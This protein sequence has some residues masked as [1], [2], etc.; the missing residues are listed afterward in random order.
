MPTKSRSSLTSSVLK[1][2][3][4]F[5]GVQ[6]VTILC[7]IVRV[8]LVALWIGAVGVGLFGIF[9]SALDT[10]N[11]L[12][13][14][15]IRASAV[16]D[17]AASPRERLPRLLCAVR[18]WGWMLG[19]M[20]AAVTL[21]CSR[22]LSVISFGTPDQWWGFAFLSVTVMMSA[23]SAA[24]GAIFQG[25]QRYRKLANSSV[26]GA[27]G[28]LLISIPLFRY[29]GIGS[30][31]PSIAAYVTVTWVAL[32]IYRAR[33]EKPDPPLT[34]RETLST[35][36]GFLMLGA[37]M[38]VTSFV[39][40]LAT[41][42]FIAWLNNR[43][44]TEAVGY[45]QAG[46]T[47][48]NRY[49]GLIFTA[50]SMEYYPRLASVVNSPRRTSMFVAHETRI[51]LL[52]LLP[53]VGMFVALAPLIVRMLYTESFLVV[54]PFISWGIAGT[55]FRAI[56][57]CMAFTI[58]AKGDGKTFLA[59]EIL[60]AVM[61]VAINIA[62][63]R[64]GGLDWMGYAYCVWYLL[65]TVTVGAVYFRRYS[66]TISTGV[67]KLTAATVVAAFAFPLLA[68]LVFRDSGLSPAWLAIPATVAAAISARALLRRRR[69]TAK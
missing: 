44:T 9:N 35:G 33:I 67:K 46:F 40:N 60:S 58:L 3:G 31:V 23:V 11:S 2:M 63:Y 37:Y 48:V 16:R 4:I 57:W 20:G 45:Y 39:T 36:K 26:A 7:S 27:V 29:L 38:T 6:V 69:A 51:T 15:G 50:I 10:I 1:V 14:L 8:K 53:L 49:V 68:T 13:Q 56:S 34:M 43:E 24:E 32:G 28:G 65:Y 64:L 17:I 25:L 47:L 62:A 5:G 55:L 19:M 52:L 66:L 18:R 42:I 30:I 61:M 21:L 59:T 41:Y 54:V 12:C 22:W